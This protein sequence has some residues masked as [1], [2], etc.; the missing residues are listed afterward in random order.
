MSIFG[1]VL[2]RGGTRWSKPRLLSQ[3]AHSSEQ[4]PLLFVS[5]DGFLHLVHTAQSVRPAEDD[6]WQS[7]GQAFSMQWTARLRH[8]TT[9][10]WRHKWSPAK[11]LLNESAFCRH[12]PVR[13]PD[14]SRLLPIYFSTE[15]GGGFGHDHSAVLRLDHAG[16]PVAPP[17][18][19]GGSKG[20]VHGCLVPSIDGERWLQFFRSRLADCIYRSVGSLDGTQ[21]TEPEPIA[22]PN[23]NSSM[24]A[25]RMRSGLL[26]MAFNRFGVAMAKEGAWGDAIWPRTRWPLSLAASDDDGATWPWIRDIDAGL[27]YCGHANWHWNGQLAYPSIVEGEEGEI[28]LAYSWGNRAAI[29]HVSLHVNDLVGNSQAHRHDQP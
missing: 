8:Q 29:R 9:Q 18:T 16:T 2:K 13:A 11:E 23:N 7:S 28:H 5:D 21:W 17:I 24:Q 3:D 12:P 22:L 27:G 20:R 10:S 4:N 14:G 19:V 1:S 26:I 6:S 15:E 25:I